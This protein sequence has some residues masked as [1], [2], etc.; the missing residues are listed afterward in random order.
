MDE[1]YYQR[2]KERIRAYQREYRKNHP[3]KT[4]AQ[5]VKWQTEHAEEKKAYDKAYKETHKDH[6]RE[7]ARKIRLANPEKHCDYVREWSRLNPEKVKASSKKA[8]AKRGAKRKKYREDNKDRLVAYERERYSKDP[9]FFKAKSS[10]WRKRNP[11]LAKQHKLVRR[12]KMYGAPV[13][14]II[15]IAQWEMEWRALESV[16][17][18]YCLSFFPPK[19]CDTDHVIPLS[20][21]GG[22]HSPS[23]V[24][25]SCIRCNRSKHDKLLSEWIP[26][27]TPQPRSLCLNQNSSQPKSTE[28][29]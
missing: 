23:N 11:H 24:A 26:P 9:E 12:S 14:D 16:Q 18:V 3:E 15:K 5:N 21:D 4:R 19:K 8:Y 25:I 6:A 2:N 10:E 1:D 27:F 28:I 7:L 22:E 20:R 17:C 13:I 29:P